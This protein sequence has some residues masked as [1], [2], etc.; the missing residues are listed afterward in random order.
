[1]T[2]RGLVALFLAIVLSACGT[3][4]AP[5]APEGVQ[6]VLEGRLTVNPAIDSVA[7]YRGFE[8]VVSY[9]DSTGVDTLGAA[10]TDSTGAFAMT[11]TAP[12]RGVYPLTIR[13]R[14]QLL[15]RDEL[16]VADGDTA[17]LVAELPLPSNRPLRIRSRENAAWMAYRNA[18]AQHNQLLAEMLQ[19]G[20]YGET[21]ARRNIQQ[22]ATI[23]WSLR[24]TY[25]GTVASEVAVAEAVAM[26][27]GW[28]DSLAVAWAQQVDP[29]NPSFVEVVRVARQAQARRSGQ[30]AALRLLRTFQAAAPNDETRAGI[31]SEVVLAHMDSLA[32]DSALAAARA[33]ADDYPDTR[34]ADWTERAIYEIETLMPGMEAPSFAVRTAAGDSLRLADLRGRITVLEFYAPRVQAFQRELAARS[35]LVRAAA[36]APFTLVSYSAEPDTL[37]NEAFLEGRDVPGIHVFAPSDGGAASLPRTYNV[38]TLPTRYLIDREGRIVGKYVGPAMTTLQQDVLALIQPS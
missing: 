35:A 34:W 30:A 8:V 17:R 37:L 28:N 12:D 26:L 6:S 29:G 38:N 24:D 23:L 32:Q 13:R 25:S 20:E 19:R 36:D 2:D 10:T 16:V 15:K 5:E 3:S 9:R 14:G 21:G 7:D 27:G 11:V 4:S 1:M 22:T 31:Q 18:R 33:L